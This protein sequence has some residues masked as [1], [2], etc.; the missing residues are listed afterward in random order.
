[1]NSAMQREAKMNPQGTTREETNPRRS[2]SWETWTA[3][4]AF[5]LAALIRAGVLKRIPW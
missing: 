3:L 1:M 4:I 5:T 2:F